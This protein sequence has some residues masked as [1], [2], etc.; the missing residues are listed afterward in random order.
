[1]DGDRYRGYVSKAG[2]RINGENCRSDSLG[3]S[4]QVA[5]KAPKFSDEYTDGESDFQYLRSRALYRWSLH[6]GL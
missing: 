1:M 3:S 2:T 6:G 5:A 4:A